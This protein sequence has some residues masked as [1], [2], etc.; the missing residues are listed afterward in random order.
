[1]V[2]T[3]HMLAGAAIGAHSPN[4]WAAFCFGLISHYLLDS[5]PHWE[6]LDS[7]KI[8]KFKHIAKIFI[9]FIIGIFIVL[10]VSW[11]LK[12]VVIS[13]IVGSLLPDIIQFLYNNFKM[14][15]LSPFSVFHNKVHYHKRTPFLKGLIYQVIILVISVISLYFYT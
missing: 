13:G 6:Y 2:I 4:V 5:L 1:M 12:I 8:N 10:I 11:P 3:P 15:F 7:I 14:K 9:D